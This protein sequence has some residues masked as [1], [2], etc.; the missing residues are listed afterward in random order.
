MT[1]V[2]KDEHVPEDRSAD[3][4]PYVGD[5]EALKQRRTHDSIADIFEK[6]GAKRKSQEEGPTDDL[7]ERYIA[8]PLHAVFLFTSEDSLVS[9]YVLDNWGALD[10]LSDDF[11]DIH[12]AL[13]QFEYRED[14]Y[15]YVRNLRIPGADSVTVSSLPGILFWDLQGNS[16]FVSFGSSC[17]MDQMKHIL[18]TLFEEIHRGPTIGAVKRAKHVLSRS[19]IVGAAPDARTY[20]LIEAAILAGRKIDDHDAP[21]L[22]RMIVVMGLLAGLSIAG[23]IIGIIWNATSPTSFDVFGVTLSTGHV[24]V[25]FTALGLICMLFTVRGILKFLRKRSSRPRN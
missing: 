3:V 18:R 23:G 4:E 9:K 20:D 15:D 6:L 16:A 13:D 7:L 2:G 12:P 14:A 11:C 17:T 5:P 21:V 25:A 22:D 8:V 10:S 24:G 19:A 1:L